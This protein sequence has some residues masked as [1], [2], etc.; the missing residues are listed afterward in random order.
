M[1]VPFSLT[2]SIPNNTTSAID[3]QYLCMKATTQSNDAAGENILSRYVM[4]FFDGGKIA[5]MLW[6][7]SS[8][9]QRPPDTEILLLKL[10]G[11]II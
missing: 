7:G 9:I 2:P 1:V 11:T 4:I 8:D 6:Y 10:R 3:P 5:G